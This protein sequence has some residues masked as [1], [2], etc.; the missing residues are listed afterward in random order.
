MNVNEP[1]NVPVVLARN[2]DCDQVFALYAYALTVF[3]LSN[4]DC[5]QFDGADAV[6]CVV[7]SPK[8]IVFPDACSDSHDCETPGDVHIRLEEADSAEGWVRK[9]DDLHLRKLIRKLRSADSK[10]LLSRN[11]F[12][13]MVSPGVL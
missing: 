8:V 12:N 7:L 5:V 6:V 11:T 9:G 2:L 3:A 10:R 4:D 1:L 13:V